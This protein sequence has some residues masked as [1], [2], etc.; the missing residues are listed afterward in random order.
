[1]AKKIM[2]KLRAFT[3]VELMV[4][5]GFIGVVV[6]GIGIV[7]VDS[8]RGWNAMYNR[9]YSPVAID[10]EAARRTFDSLVRKADRKNILLDETGAWVE[11][12]YY[13]DLASTY[14]DRY[15]NFYS[16]GNELK[17]EYGTVD[18]EQN[19]YESSTQTLSSNVYSCA[20]VSVDGSVQ[21]VLRLD[22]GSDSA[23]VVSSA[24]AHN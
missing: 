3:L 14:V 1:M 19:T 13:Q 17:V 16:L 6:V 11:V 7:L 23:T 8:Q 9:I 24:V 22:N 18:T 12:R 20:F 4:A 21:M 10:A 2:T 5:T 15:A